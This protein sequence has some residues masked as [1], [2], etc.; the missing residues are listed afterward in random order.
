MSRSKR[1]PVPDEQRTKIEVRHAAEMAALAE[2]AAAADRLAMVETRRLEVLADQDQR[3][4]EARAERVAAAASLARLI[5]VGRASDLTGL[6]AA[7][8]R[9]CT[10]ENKVGTL[11]STASSDI[12]GSTQ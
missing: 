2:H 11:T 8:L 12:R 7:E 4:A 1:L 9:R 10:R 6:K 5:G 3:V